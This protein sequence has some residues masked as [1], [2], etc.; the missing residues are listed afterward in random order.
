MS[1]VWTP[2]F[3]PRD[4]CVFGTVDLLGMT[5]GCNVHSYKVWGGAYPPFSVGD[6]LFLARVSEHTMSPVES[7]KLAQSLFM[8]TKGAIKA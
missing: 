1:S 8:V 2:R 5:N 4:P 3:L 6:S 7:L